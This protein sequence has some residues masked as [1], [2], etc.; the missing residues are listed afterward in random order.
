MQQCVSLPVVG[1]RK[2]YYTKLIKFGDVRIS[3]VTGWWVNLVASMIVRGGSTFWPG[4]GF[5]M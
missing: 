5:P 3:P 1:L 2:P 4:K